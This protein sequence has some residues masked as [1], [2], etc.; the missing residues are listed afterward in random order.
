MKS[1][2]ET[3]TG[4]MQTRSGAR[5]DGKIKRAEFSQRTGMGVER[6]PRILFCWQAAGGVFHAG[7]HYNPFTAADGKIPLSMVQVKRKPQHL[8]FY[9]HLHALHPRTLDF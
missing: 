7:E 2:R 3:K 1:P 4:K 6:V 8:V 9:A 5:P